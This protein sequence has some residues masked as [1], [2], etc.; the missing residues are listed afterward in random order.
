MLSDGSEVA[1]W[2]RDPPMRPLPDC[3]K[4]KPCDV[5]SLVDAN[6]ERKYST[7]KLRS[8]EFEGS[9]HFHPLLSKSVIDL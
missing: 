8:N 6:N 7:V 3:I 5:S 4:G 1:K 2:V 9:N